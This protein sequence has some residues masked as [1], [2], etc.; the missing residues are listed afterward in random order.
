MDETRNIGERISAVAARSHPELAGVVGSYRWDVDGK[1]SWY[2]SVDHGVA[3][4]REG[5][6]SADCIIAS[7]EEDFWAIIDGRQNLITALMQGRVH[8]E[9]DLALAQKL[10]GLLPGPQD[11]RVTPAAVS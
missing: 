7:N 3:T 11:A 4:A 8:I 10:H 1:G 9:G 2:V 6:L 5:M